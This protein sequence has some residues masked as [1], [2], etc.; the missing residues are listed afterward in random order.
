MYK[1]E[2]IQMKATGIVRRI[3]ELGRVVIPKEIR[4]TLRIK[5]GDPLEIFTDH[6]ELLLKKFSAISSLGEEAKAFIESLAEISENVFIACD[7]DA[8]ICTSGSKYKDYVGKPLT[9]ELEK[10]LR[11][12]KSIISNKEDGGNVL[13]IVKGEE[14]NVNGQ[15]IVPIINNG[16]LL[17]AI[18][19]L[20]KERKLDNVDVKLAQLGA[21]FLAN[22]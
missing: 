21:N 14:L 8:V 17:G 10:C 13:G 12:R 2:K 3:D 7:T 11:E 15:I 4:K 19:M 5:E 16:D 18:I 22:K 9:Y 1:G 20:S 6:E